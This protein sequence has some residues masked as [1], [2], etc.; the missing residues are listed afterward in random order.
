MHKIKLILVLMSYLPII[1]IHIEWSDCKIDKCKDWNKLKSS[2]DVLGNE[3]KL[4]SRICSSNLLAEQHGKNNDSKFGEGYSVCLLPVLLAQALH[5]C[6]LFFYFSSY[7]FCVFVATIPHAW[8]K[9]N[10]NTLQQIENVTQKRHR[11]FR[12]PVFYP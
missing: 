3:T 7:V 1:N 5:V 4:Y 6:I 2:L 12:L 9:S 10:M 11:L 8:Q